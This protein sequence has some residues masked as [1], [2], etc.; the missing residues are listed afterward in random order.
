MKARHV[1]SADSVGEVAPQAAEGRGREAGSRVRAASLL[2]AILALP[3]LAPALSANNVLV[4]YN[5]ASPDGQTIANYYAQDHPGVQLLGLNNVPV[6]DQI[7]DDQYLNIIRPQVLAAVGSS[8]DAIVTTKGLPLRI[9]DTQTPSSFPFVYTDPAGLQRTV[10]SDSYKP[11]SS[12]E[13][14][15]SKVMTVSTAAQMGDQTWFNPG[16][17]P[18]AA[19]NPYYRRNSRFSAS[20]PLNNQFR[21]T[22]RLDGFTTA[23]VLASIDRAQNVYV[24]PFGH[25][26]VVDNSPAAAATNATRMAA[27]ANNVLAPSGQSYVYDTQVSPVLTAAKPV[28][29]YVSFGTNDGSG[30]LQPDYMQSQLQFQ[31]AKGAI[32]ETYESYNGYSFDPNNR[33]GQGLI[34]DWVH[35]GGTAGIA[36]VEEPGA[37]TV[38]MTNEDRMFS[39]MLSGYTWSEAAWN[40][41]P[42][43]SYVNTVIGDPLMVWHK[44]LP[45]DANLDGCVNFA[46]F[47]A[48]AQHWLKPGTF[49]QG[50]FNGDGMVDYRDY[51]ILKSNWLKSTDQQLATQALALPDMPVPEPGT[52]LSI[53][54][55][56]LGTL[57]RRG[58]SCR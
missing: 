24:V 46:D 39:M 15:L 23:D 17:P 38:T 7:T 1:V 10:Y 8:V 57:G 14:E 25:T 2:A 19:S 35:A 21:L 26:I 45:G 52:A 32:A 50:D 31:L 56:A 54:A 44:W 37:S 4:L 20:D 41:T 29:G 30:Q 58:R 47:Q 27:L 6:T 12:L 3:E 40:A 36:Q 9:Y 22:A 34:G 51:Q 43:A 16:V 49:A 28:I 33:R 11:Y 53:I 18:G 5:T 42:Q 13:S 48:L 55:I